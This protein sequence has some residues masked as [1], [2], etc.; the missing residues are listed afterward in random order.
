M[1][2][3]YAVD[4]AIIQEQ[5]K[6]SQPIPLKLQ[7]LHLTFCVTFKWYTC[8]VLRI[9]ISA[10]DFVNVVSFLATVVCKSNESEMCKFHS[11]FS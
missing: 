6:L 11:L 8:N 5:S 1:L 10:V 9:D 2:V 7:V 3:Q 4:M